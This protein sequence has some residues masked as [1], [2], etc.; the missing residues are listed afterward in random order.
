[1]A[2]LST[3]HEAFRR[4]VRT[5]IESR[6]TPHADEWERNG[7]FPRSVFAE[8]GKEGL[9]GLT[10][11]RKYGGAGLDFGYNVVLAEEL[12]RSK[13]MGLSLSLIAQT[14][15]FPPLLATPEPKNRNRAS[16]PP[17][18]ARRSAAS[19]PE[20]TGDRYRT[21]RLCRAE[22]DGDFWNHRRK[23]SSPTPIAD[24][25]IVLVR[26]RTEPPSAC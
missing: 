1:M 2:L 15:I 8:F 5:F 17:S 14:N 25:L 11:D 9:L 18:E 19:P 26:T 7:A 3:D 21:L 23:S 10:H 4:K 13:M 22:D 12:P 16:R 6:F 24:F 20:P